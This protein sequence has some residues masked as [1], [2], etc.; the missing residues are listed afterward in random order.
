MVKEKSSAPRRD[1]AVVAAM[2]A[3]SLLALS[4]CQE[5]GHSAGV[6][7]EQSKSVR[8]TDHFQ[9]VVANG[10]TLVAVGAFGVVASSTDGGASW[11]RSELADGAPLVRVA[12]CGDGSLVAL[13]F[14]GK[15]WRAPADLSAWTA[16]ALPPADAVLDATCTGDNRIWVTGARGLLVVSDDGGKNWTAKSLDED[17]QLL[18]IQFPTAAFGVVTGEFGRVLVTHDGGASWGQA[19]SLGED[20]YPQAMNFENDR[21][22]LVVGLSGAVQETRDG[23][24]S[25]LRTKAPVE[26]PLYGVLALANGE[27]VVAGAAGSAARL[28]GGVWTRIEGLPLTDFRGMAATSTGVMLAGTGALLPLPTA[29]ATTAKTN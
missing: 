23:G 16:S 27:A 22:G 15:I 24:A 14:S 1:G 13:D 12:A 18:N 10:R 7:A 29:A 17:I 5:D 19:G 2:M 11:K 6:A 8:R 9:S 25:W 4:A 21:R 28:A 20:F 26:A 3:L